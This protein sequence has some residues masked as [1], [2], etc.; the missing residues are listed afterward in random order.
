MIFLC[1]FFSA[2]STRHSTLDTRLFSL[3]QLVR[4]GEH[5]R[6]DREADLLRRLEIDHELKLGRLLDRKVGGLGTLQ[7][8]VHIGGN[9][10]VAVREV[11]P[12]GHEP[13][14]IYSFSGES[15]ASTVSARLLLLVLSGANSSKR[16][17]GAAAYISL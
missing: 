2:L 6:R 3:D 1:M 12:V 15:C 17:F 16:R 14:G 13:T 9:A 8:S 4:P 7:D 11:R 5:V 10:P